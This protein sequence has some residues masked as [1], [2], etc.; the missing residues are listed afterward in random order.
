[1]R[2]RQLCLIAQDLEPT[3][4]TLAALFG[5]KVCYRDPGVAQFGLA[6]GL[7]ALGGDFLEVV[8][9]IKL[10]T[11]GG[12]HL[13]RHGDSGYMIILQCGDALSARERITQF[14][15]R[16]VWR[17]EGRQGAHEGVV[18]THFHP[19]DVGAA[20]LSIDSMGVENWQ[21]PHARW[22][23]AGDQWPQLL[24]RSDATSHVG[25]FAAAEIAAQ[26]PAKLAAHWG[27]L[28]DLPVRLQSDQ[29]LIDLDQAVLRFV[30]SEGGGT[31]GAD[32]LAAIDL[33]AGSQGREG[34]YR[35][36]QELH[37]PR[38]SIS[39]SGDVVRVCGIDLRVI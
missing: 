13:A 9:P 4:D 19:R 11:A 14:G 23:W 10:N 33:N 2:L 27:R 7:F 17:I 25:R 20:I 8:S 1:M 5:I 34:F 32:R 31:R 36:A 26:D 30:P 29:F 37:L 21:E 35:A 12:R 3:L 15:A 18:A 6:N 39:S 38:R 16:A 22:V 28:L 24:Q